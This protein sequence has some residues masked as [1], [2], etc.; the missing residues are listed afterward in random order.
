M[1]KFAEI[2]RIVTDG[3]SY[4]SLANLEALDSWSH[5]SLWCGSASEF[6]SVHSLILTTTPT[7]S[8]PEF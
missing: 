1:C 6:V 8:C 2:N 3:L 7:V 4:N 5:G